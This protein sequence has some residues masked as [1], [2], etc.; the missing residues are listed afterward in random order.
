MTDEILEFIML[1][2]GYDKET[3]MQIYNDEN[4]DQEQEGKQA[5]VA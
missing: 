3:I 1:V 2:T 5:V 4:P